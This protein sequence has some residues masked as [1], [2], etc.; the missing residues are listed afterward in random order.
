MKIIILIF[1]ATL[2]F[3][4]NIFAQNHDIP[5]NNAEKITTILL[6][7]QLVNEKG[8][9]N[10]NVLME[11]VNFP[12]FNVGSAHRHPCPL[13]AYVLEGELESTFE[14]KTYHFKV[15]DEFYEQKNGLHQ[16]TKNPD[17]VHPAKLLVFYIS[18]KGATTYI[19]E[20]H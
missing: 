13:F 8:I 19:P 4:T 1:A 11:I 14:G 10:K 9:E 20:K 16:G 18:E 2:C 17:A 15:G 12:P 6:L 3:S 7:E 5:I